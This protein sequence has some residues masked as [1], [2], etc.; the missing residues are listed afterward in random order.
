MYYL[1]KHPTQTRNAGRDGKRYASQITAKIKLTRWKQ[2]ALLEKTDSQHM[3]KSI[4]IYE[5]CMIIKLNV[6][7]NIA[8]NYVTENKNYKEKQTNSQLYG[9]FKNISVKKIRPKKKSEIAMMLNKVD[10][11][12]IINLLHS[13]AAE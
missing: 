4:Y 11:I 5:E 6:P 2:K 1:Q 12:E 9:Q 8:S 3:I 13:T 10:L 7:N